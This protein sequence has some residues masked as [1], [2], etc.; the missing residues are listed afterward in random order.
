MKIRV[1]LPNIIIVHRVVYYN[2]MKKRWD[3]DWLCPLCNVVIFGRHDA[4][5]KC[6]TP[7][8]KPGDWVCRRSP[9]TR[10]F[11]F[12]SR[13]ECRKC[14]LAKPITCVCADPQFEKI[15]ING[16]YERRG[17][18]ERCLLPNLIPWYVFNLDKQEAIIT[19]RGIPREYWKYSLSGP[20][21]HPSHNK[22]GLGELVHQHAN[23]WIFQTRADIETEL[24]LHEKSSVLNILIGDGRLPN[25]QW[26]LNL[27][28]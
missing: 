10:E 15:D 11:N 13:L 4:C 16:D 25:W 8:L 14:G 6:K 23:V 22:S 27:N 1:Y 5:K 19:K 2:N 20:G 12:A 18:C 24:K 9:C 7:K 28:R 26:S 3:P 21:S 17:D